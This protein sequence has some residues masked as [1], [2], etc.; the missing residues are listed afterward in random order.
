MHTR[1]GYKAVSSVNSILI[2][3]ELQGGARAQANHVR[4][5]QAP[6]L[7]IRLCYYESLLSH[8]P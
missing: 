2:K 8:N 7:R 1:I 3:G 5:Q 4:A 6:G